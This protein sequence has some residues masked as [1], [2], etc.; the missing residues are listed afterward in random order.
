[1]NSMATIRG[2]KPGG[3]ACTSVIINL[4]TVLVRVGLK[5]LHYESGVSPYGLSVTATFV[6]Y[7]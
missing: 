4:Q 6:S 5:E 2:Q 1:M 3:L 7:T